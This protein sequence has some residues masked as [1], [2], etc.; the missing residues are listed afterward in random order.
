[1]A[2]IKNDDFYLYTGL[3]ANGDECHEALT[4]LNSTGIQFRHLHYGDPAQHNEVLT[5]VGTWFQ[6]QGIT[7]AFPFVH[8]TEV[9]EFNDNPYKVVRIVNGLTAIKAADWNGLF[10]FAGAPSGG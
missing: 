7:P 1:M 9:N 5:N 4:F 8:Y 10:N 6:D 2:H 3:T